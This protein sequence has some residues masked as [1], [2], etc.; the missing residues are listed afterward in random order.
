MGQAADT[1]KEPAGV[2]AYTLQ[3]RDP[4]ATACT[5]AIDIRFGVEGNDPI[6]S[7]F[8]A[9]NPDGVFETI[10]APMP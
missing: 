5:A 1:G 6:L 2:S 4:Y 7:S 9:P 8:R 10:G 3:C